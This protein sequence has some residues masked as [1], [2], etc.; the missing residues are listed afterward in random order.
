MTSAL[1]CSDNR[2][3]SGADSW[4]RISVPSSTTRTI[5]PDSMTSV[6]RL[7]SRTLSRTVDHTLRTSAALGSAETPTGVADAAAGAGA[8]SGSG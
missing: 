7:R 6:V 3:A 2:L 5:A 8:G 1:R 4:A